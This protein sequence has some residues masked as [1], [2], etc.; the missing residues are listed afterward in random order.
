METTNYCGEP[1][2]SVHSGSLALG[3]AQTDSSS[4]RGGRLATKAAPEP[5]TERRNLRS[6]GSHQLGPVEP[7]LQARASPRAPYCFAS[8][9]VTLLSMRAA[10]PNATTRHRFAVTRWR[11]TQSDANQSLSELAQ[12][13]IFTATWLTLWGG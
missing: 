8:A 9:A 1:R 3:Q 13:M 5:N 12:L 10:A 6:R 7:N 4:V 11:M 2:H